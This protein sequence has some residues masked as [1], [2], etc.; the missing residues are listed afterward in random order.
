MRVIIAG[1]GIGGLGAALALRRRG[2]AVTVLEQASALGEAGAGI[3]LGPNAVRVLE[4]WGIGAAVRAA[5]FR[6]LAAEVRDHVSG[7]LLLRTT[8]GEAAQRRW[9]APYLQVHRADLQAILLDALSAEGGSELRLDARVV[10]V[11][12][13]AEEVT[14]A[15]A[16]GERVQG[17]ALVGADG[18]RSAVQEALFGPSPARF[19][20]QVAWRGL[21]EASRLPPGLISPV[22][23]VWA[24]G[25]RHFVHYPVRGGALVNFVGVVE[26]D[27][28][29]ESW[30]A[31]GNAG[32]LA[33][34]FS[35]WPAS[36]TALIAAAGP[37]WRWALF[38]RPPLARWSVGRATLL[39]DAA[40][41]MLPFLAQGAAMAIE[42]AEA[43]ARLLA[44]GE[45]VSAAL[46][47]YEGA[48]RSRTRKVQAWSR[49]NARLF[50]LPPVVA[51]AAFG[52]AGALDRVRGRT[53][54]ER[55]DWLYGYG[56]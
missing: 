20:G 4:G 30:T 16:T 8:L 51:G 52:A 3:Q 19:T 43:L 54:A 14:A 36:V 31:P 40:H 45:E 26:R 1:G 11:A 39:G 2:L 55:F 48:R 22:A 9:G 47:A 24:G 38:D 32:E 35:G 49:R 42:D 15:L 44:E 50:H 23:A 34:E 29:E 46:T 12:Q 13:S 10:A 41:P 18:V 5:A 28:R 53:G 56:Q 33:A 17:S 25:G 37:A 27:W 21:V 7:R 6:P